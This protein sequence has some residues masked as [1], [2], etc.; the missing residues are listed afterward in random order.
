MDDS[1]VLGYIREIK[2]SD[3]REITQHT[4]SASCYAAPRVM[5]VHLELKLYTPVPENLSAFRAVVDLRTLLV[6][7]VSGSLESSGVIL[8]SERPRLRAINPGRADLAEFEYTA[9]EDS[10]LESHECADEHR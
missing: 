4:Y 10:R 9:S 3:E 1:Q 8:E 7:T 2:F 5:T 6:T